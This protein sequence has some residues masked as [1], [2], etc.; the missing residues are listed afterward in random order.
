M[1][2]AGRIAGGFE[3]GGLMLALAVHAAGEQALARARMRREILQHNAR[4][5]AVRAARARRHAAAE[6]KRRELMSMW[7][8]DRE[9]LG[10]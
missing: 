1:S 7:L 6:A 9:Q 8:R 5:A 2:S 10:A 4:V 3:T